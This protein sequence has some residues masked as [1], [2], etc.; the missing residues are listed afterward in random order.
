ME[1]QTKFPGLTGK[2]D[3][4]GIVRVN[5]IF[6]RIPLSEYENM[7]EHEFATIVNTTKAVVLSA[8]KKHLAHRYY[9]AIDDVAQEVYLRAYKGLV[10]DGFKKASSIETW[11]YTIAKNESS[12]MNDRLKREEVKF[13]KSIIKMK[14]A[15]E[16]EKAAEHDLLEEHIIQLKSLIKKLPEKYSS[17]MEL[18]ARGFTEKQIADHL[19]LKR[20]TVKSRASRGRELMRRI[21]HGGILL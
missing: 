14:E 9:H 12:R 11:L 21:A 7:D 10:K 5:Y 15:I 3:T 8:V 2:E 16:N 18:A 6:Q 1:P 19:N 4:A 17:V 13:N 20:G